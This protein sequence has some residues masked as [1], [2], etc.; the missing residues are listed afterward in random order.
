MAETKGVD[1]IVKIA[2]T[3]STVATLLH[4]TAFTLEETTETLDVTTMG[5]DYRQILSTFKSFTIS[6][7]G[8]WDPSETGL[9]HGAAAPTVQAGT[10]IDFEL[11]PAGTSGIFYSGSAIVTSISRSGSFDGAVEFSLS[12]DGTGDLAYENA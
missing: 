3:G 7:D 11:Y 2:A 12:A 9:G 4:V 5:D 6:V 8:Y 10:T 1:G